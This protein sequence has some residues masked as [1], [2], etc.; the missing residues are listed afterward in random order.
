M[1]IIPKKKDVIE[2]ILASPL[3]RRIANWEAQ[4]VV[5][6]LG[7]D[8]FH[9]ILENT[10]ALAEVPIKAQKRAYLTD[11]AS[12]ILSVWPDYMFLVRNGVSPYASA[13]VAEAMGQGQ[14]QDRRPF[15][16]GT[17]GYPQRDR[18]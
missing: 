9:H 14:V 18:H 16:H 7:Q 15:R 17:A 8:S 4:K 5:E 3:F 13:L 12:E 11:R 1:L 6:H 10:P 2:Q